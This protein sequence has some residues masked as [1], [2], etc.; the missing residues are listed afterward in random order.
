MMK[1]SELFDV[2]NGLA[3]TGLSIESKKQ[4]HHLPYIR[5][6]STQEGT[7]AGW[8]LLRDVE[9]RYIYP[10]GTLFVS[11]NGEGSHTFSYVSSFSFVPNSDVSVLIPKRSMSLVEKLYYAH[12]ITLNRYK[13]SYGRKPKGKRL[14]SIELPDAMP[15]E[16]Q[17]KSEKILQQQ[18][19]KWN[20][21]DTIL[22]DF[23]TNQVSLVEG[24]EL[25][26]L[27]D[28]F[29]ISYGVNME[30]YLLFA[31]MELMELGLPSHG[32]IQGNIRLLM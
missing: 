13:F 18:A 31:E 32:L 30:L 15:I 10:K 7:I 5:P 8:V 29:D 4:P 6:S 20:Q 25:V 24:V 1:L 26:E 22:S 19:S 3:S 28:L 9:E 16:L 23:R 11:T 17:E 14:R 27:Q 21:F 12:C 2:E